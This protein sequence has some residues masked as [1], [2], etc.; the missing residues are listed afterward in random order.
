MELQVKSKSGEPEVI[1]AKVTNIGNNLRIIPDVD[2]RAVSVTP[3]SEAV[4]L[5]SGRQFRDLV[6]ASRLAIEETDEEITNRAVDKKPRPKPQ[7]QQ[8]GEAAREGSDGAVGNEGEAK[9]TAAE[10]LEKQGDMTYREFVD[11]ARE[12][13]GD[14]FPDHPAQPKK[15][16]LVALLEAQS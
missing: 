7:P 15:R 1:R 4:L 10:L 6:K 5:V 2:G 14:E 16:D 9:M 13:L 12:V 11:A 8:Q 3:G